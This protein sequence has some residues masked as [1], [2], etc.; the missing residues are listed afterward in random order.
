V[1]T[2][3]VQCPYCG[4]FGEVEGVA[5]AFRWLPEHLVA[6]PERPDDDEAT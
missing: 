2:W 1:T 4:A 3:T 5:D 6:C